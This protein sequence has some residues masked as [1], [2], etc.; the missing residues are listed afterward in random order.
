MKREKN[1][2]AQFYAAYGI[3]EEPEGRD[4]VKDKRARV[5]GTKANAPLTEDRA[6]PFV[7]ASDLRAI[8]VEAQ[9]A[10]VEAQDGFDPASFLS[11]LLG[12]KRSII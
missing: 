1:E 6:F 5:Y 8:K 7:R 9:P 4:R 11:L 12:M 10:K 3:K 2:K